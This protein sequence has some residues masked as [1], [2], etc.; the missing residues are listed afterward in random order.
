MELPA[1]E[2]LHLGDPRCYWQLSSRATESCAPSRRAS[3][4][5]GTAVC[6]APAPWGPTALPAAGP[7]PSGS[8]AA[9][10]RAPVP[11][12]RRLCAAPSL[13]STAEVSTE[14]PRGAGRLRCRRQ[15]E[16]AAWHLPPLPPGAAPASA[17]RLPLGIGSRGPHRR[18]S[19]AATKEPHWPAFTPLRERGGRG[20]GRWRL[21]GRR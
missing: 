4:S 20:S 16:W 6:R 12:D 21:I 7:P 9:D 8:R 17:R 13:L 19:S 15:T 10:H 14:G 2:L 3:G 11:S 5:H 1:V 18:A